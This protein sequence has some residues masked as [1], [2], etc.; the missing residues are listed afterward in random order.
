VAGEASSGG[1]GNSSGAGGRFVVVDQAGFR[2]VVDA[3]AQLEKVA[4]G[5]QFVEGPAWSA[6]GGGY[7]V[8]SDIPANEIKRWS[9]REGVTTVRAPSNNANGNT[10]DRDGRL[11]TCEHSGRRVSIQEHDGTVRTL[12]DRFEGRRLSSPNDVVV[13]S[14]GTVWF[15]DPPYGLPDQRE[16]K[17]QDKDYVFRLDPESGELRPVA[18]DFHRPNGL[19]FSPDER[20]LY[21]ADS[22]DPHHIRVFDVQPGGTLA[23]GRVFCTIDPGIPDGVRCDT[24]GR[25][26]SSAADGV[27]IFAASGALLGKIITPDAPGR[28]DPARI[29][30]EVV[31]NLC[32]GGEDGQTLFMTA[33]RSLY[34]LRVKT[35]GAGVAAQADR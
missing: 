5:F 10:R 35:T 32:F 2:Q 16:G 33:C 4:G 25:V 7:L 22:G 28:R 20:L 9:P 15:T 14:D 18:D 34:S 8:F 17:E 26:W 19:C 12:V 11:V 30:P 3:G 29:G 6:A 27:H 13:K 21:I 31:A 24:A 23:N 1:S